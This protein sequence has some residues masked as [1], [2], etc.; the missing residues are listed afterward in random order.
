[1]TE[2][3]FE[4]VCA[5]SCLE[6]AQGEFCVFYDA[7]DDIAPGQIETAVCLMLEKTTPPSR[8]PSLRKGIHSQ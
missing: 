7:S 6:Q 5:Q 1:M 2:P 4:G 8:R 3:S